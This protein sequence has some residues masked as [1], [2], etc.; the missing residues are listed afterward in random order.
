[1]YHF[2]SIA[3][4]QERMLL[5]YSVQV[6]VCRCSRYQNPAPEAP[7][8]CS[9]AVSWMWDWWEYWCMWHLHS[10]AVLVAVSQRGKQMLCL[11]RGVDHSDNYSQILIHSQRAIFKNCFRSNNHREINALHCR[12]SQ[13]HSTI[14]IKTWIW[15]GSMT[16]IT[17][18]IRKTKSVCAEVQVF[19]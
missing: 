6:Y 4:F 12:P 14:F 19:H 13:S 15:F 18:L 16:L 9:G 1:M 5:P 2:I 11:S 3:A 10:A 7:V 8:P 17:M